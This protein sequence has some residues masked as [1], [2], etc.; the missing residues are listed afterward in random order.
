MYNIVKNK[1]NNNIIVL[2]EAY[3]AISIIAR[4]Y[5]LIVVNYQ[6]VFMRFA[7]NVRP[8][9]TMHASALS[10]ILRSSIYIVF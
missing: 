8:K 10:K 3:R 6:I 9:S 4:I 7:I 2:E 5:T 1:C